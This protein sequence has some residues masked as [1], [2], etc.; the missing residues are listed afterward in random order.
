MAPPSQITLP[1]GNTLEPFVDV[2]DVAEV[3]IAALTEP[4]HLGEVYEVTGPR[5]MPSGISP[6]SCQMPL[7]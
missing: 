5:L 4:G 6:P 3:A 2:D 7:P 1:A